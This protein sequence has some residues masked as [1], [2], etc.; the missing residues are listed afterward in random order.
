MMYKIISF[1]YTYPHPNFP[2]G[3]QNPHPSLP[4]GGKEKYQAFPPWGKRERG[5]F[6]LKGKQLIISNIRLYY[7]YTNFFIDSRDSF[8]LSTYG[9]EMSD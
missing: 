6:R 8:K 1:Y 2:E 9:V 7:Y 4:P 5:L 3:T